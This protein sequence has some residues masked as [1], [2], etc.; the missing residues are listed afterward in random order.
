MSKVT[1]VT[2]IKTDISNE[3]IKDEV[4]VDTNREY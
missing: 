2:E 1:Q 3:E 4:L